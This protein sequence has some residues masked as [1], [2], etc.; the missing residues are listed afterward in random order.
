MLVC[1]QEFKGSLTALEAA[2]AI[3]AGVRAALDDVDVRVQ[4]LGDGGPGTV[5]ACLAA[6]NGT[7]IVVEVA[8]PLG[9]PVAAAYA[10]FEERGSRRVAV[11][12]S[13]AACGLVLVAPERRD[14]AQAS[15]FGV[16]ELVADAARRGAKRIVVGVGGSGTNDGGA[17][18][19]QALELRLLDA[20]GAELSRGGLALERLTRIDAG[21]VSTVLE[22]V[23]LLVAVDVT[24]P[25]LGAEGATAIYG[26]QKGVRDWEAPALDRALA[27]W[28][29]RVEA[30][31]GVSLAAEAGAGAG[32]GLPTGL[33][34]VA[35]AAGASAGIES[36]AELVA[37]AVGLRAAVEAA[38]L[39]ITGEGS[40]DAQTGY[41][42]TVAYVAGLAAELGR[43]CLAVAG[44]VDELPEGVADAET[45]TP[46]GVAI[47][48]AMAL[49]AA[50]V[51]D[52]VERLVRRWVDR[53]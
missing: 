5:D 15:T 45:S 10:L 1:P 12:E 6:G 13:A 2:E 38:E 40:L 20:G 27:R 18:A 24:N 31:L 23:E 49:G 47:E 14:P 29:G 43:P 51:Q 33:L 21:R 11:I 16:G 36:G 37:S 26:P 4:P 19:A 32:G 28:A 52:A 44:Q 34:A 25:L 53:G 17:G 35:H 39:V 9:D 22:G 48:E 30:D 8:G 41:G 3:G 50:P 46:P 42:K 7:R